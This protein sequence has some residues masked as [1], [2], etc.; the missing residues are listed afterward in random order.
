MAPKYNNYRAMPRSA[1]LTISFQMG[2]EEGGAIENLQ[3]K[4]IANLAG[5]DALW[6]HQECSK[7]FIDKKSNLIK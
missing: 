1:F 5:F 2:L 6:P 3:W 7:L 4:L